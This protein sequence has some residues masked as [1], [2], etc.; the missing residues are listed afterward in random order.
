MTVAEFIPQA[1]RAATGKLPTFTVG[2][3]KWNNL[4]S[5]ANFYI[6]QWARE[7]NVDW[8][9]L[10]DPAYSLGT[11]S[12]TDTFDL[13][14]DIRRLS[15]QE[16]YSVRIVHPNTIQYTDYGLVTGDRLKSYPTG[17][18]A[19]QVGRTVRFN[20]AFTTSS[21]QYNGELFVPVYL[22]P[23]AV[24]RTTDVIP[25]DDPNWLVLVV[26]ADYVRNDVTRKDLRADLIAEA[27][28]SMQR[29]KAD[30]E[31]Q[32]SEPLRNWNPLAHVS[33]D[34]SY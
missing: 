29:M 23:D 10:Y 12:D 13:D 2:T 9:S 21:Q 34:F 3:T 26:A 18:Y 15:Q 30:N 31:A 11:V 1:F 5:S 20:K 22:F 33:D 7:P 19:A 25:V 24:S 16:D 8:N 4:L 27:N 28:Q 17:N 14:D 6:Q 32:I